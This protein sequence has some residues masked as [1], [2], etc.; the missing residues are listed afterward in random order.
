MSIMLSLN[1]F[2][3]GADR[4]NG[5]LIVQDFIAK[6]H[7]G[8]LIVG[9]KNPSSWFEAEKTLAK[10]YHNSIEVM[11]LDLESSQSVKNCVS[12][13]VKRGIKIDCL[14]HS[15]NRLC[16][17]NKDAK[18]AFGVNFFNT[19]LLSQEM[20]TR[21]VISPS[22]RI[23]FSSSVLGCGRIFNDP[24]LARCVKRAPFENLISFAHEVIKEIDD[25]GRLNEIARYHHKL[26]LFS[27]SKFFLNRYVELLSTHQKIVEM[28]IGVFAY[29][30]GINKSLPNAAD[31]EGTIEGVGVL[32]FLM[33]V[34]FSQKDLQGKFFSENKE[35]KNVLDSFFDHPCL[36]G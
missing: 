11:Q 7:E 21:N 10:S 8:K 25:N 12:E 30:P 27:L 36:N 17:S 28:K 18:K 9:I 13:L 3:T 33:S 32:R 4:V 14:I 20:L 16:E 2:V 24:V 5:F 23:L 19:M 6:G 15:E 35:V 29:S 22:G 34:P 26:P 31:E 1:I